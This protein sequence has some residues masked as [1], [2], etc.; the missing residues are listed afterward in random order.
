MVYGMVFHVFPTLQVMVPDLQSW[1]FLGGG[2]FIYF[3]PFWS[4]DDVKN[5]G[6][7]IIYNPYVLQV[8]VLFLNTG[9]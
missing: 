3:D 8:T 7:I 5:V 6:N 1:I 2:Y 4:N 9:N